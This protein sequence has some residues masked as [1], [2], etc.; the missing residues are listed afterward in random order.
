METLGERLRWARKRLG[1]SQERLSEESNVKQGTISKI[2]RGDQSRTSYVTELATALV[3]SPHWLADGVGSAYEIEDVV[4]HYSV[5]SKEAMRTIMV[6]D[7][8]QAGGWR[9]CIDT[10]EAGDGFEEIVLSPAS[11]SRFG[12]RT[13]GLRVTGRS[14]ARTLEPGDLV[15]VDPDEPV[16]PGDIVVAK[17]DHENQATIKKYRARGVDDNGHEIF[18]LVPLNEDFATIRVDVSNPG[19]I[20]GPLVEVRRSL[21]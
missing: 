9:E 20:I 17:L 19:H 3:V 12:P 13:F 2:E 21:R 18:D 11:A 5:V 7:D 8:V 10:Y 16:Q 6:I 14:M 1:W 15:V 4:G